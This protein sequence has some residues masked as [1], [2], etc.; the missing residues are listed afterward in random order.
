RKE[1]DRALNIA[2]RIRRHRFLVSQGL[3]GRLLGLRWVLEGPPESLT[4]E[5]MLQRQDLLVRFPRF[6]EL[7]RRSAELRRTLTQLPIAPTD[8]NQIKQQQEQ[9]TELSKLSAQQESQLQLMALERVPSELAF[10]PLR[11]TK[12]IQERLPEGTI[13][14]YY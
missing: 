3:G 6:A 10:P 5:A 8:E 14:F 11:E 9:L 7:S 2:E 1:N 12:E 4:P 13:V